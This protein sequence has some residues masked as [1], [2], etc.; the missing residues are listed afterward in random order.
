MNDTP[1]DKELIK[2]TV[3]NVHRY[4]D[5]AMWDKINDYF[6]EKPYIDDAALT[7][8]AA[9]VRSVKEIISN[10]RRELRSYFYATRHRVTS[11][12]VRLKNPKEA[13]A[14]SPVM[15]QYFLNDRGQRYVLTVAGTYSYELYKRSGK[16]KI[17]SVRFKLKD[18]S[19]KQIGL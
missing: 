13:H 3:E 5:H 16:W 12:T 18:Q 9:G 15:G 2:E 19:L 8:E 14:S 17:G 4:R 1:T 6:V 11:I 7:K 10:W